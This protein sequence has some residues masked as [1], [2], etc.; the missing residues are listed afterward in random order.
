MPI[1]YA[2]RVPLAAL[3]LPEPDKGH[4]CDEGKDGPDEPDTGGEEDPDV[5]EYGCF[6]LLCFLFMDSEREVEG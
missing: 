3:G 2:G 4:Y 5:P 1:R 6:R